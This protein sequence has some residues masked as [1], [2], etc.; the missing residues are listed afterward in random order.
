MF[1]VC[2]I[3]NMK[4]LTKQAIEFAKKEL[5]INA[6]IKVANIKESKGQVASMAKTGDYYTLFIDEDS[7]K[8]A[9]VSAVCHEMTH[10]AQMER[11]DL[12][13]ENGLKIWKGVAM[14]QAEYNEQYHSEEGIEFENEAFEMQRKLAGKFW[15]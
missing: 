5:D 12:R 15:E 13:Q 3:N 14:T 10:V 6:E 8:Y 7:I 4:T 9:V 2:D 1:K 11:G